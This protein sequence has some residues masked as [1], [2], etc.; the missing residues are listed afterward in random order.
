MNVEELLDQIDDLLDKG[1][2]WPGGKRLV[3]V[4]TI[5]NLIDDIR[6]NM[7]SEV[8]QAKGIVADRAE[9]LNNAKRQEENIIRSAE[10]KAKALVADQEI[11][12][13]AQ[14]RANEI[15]SSAQTK[16]R[17]MRRAAQEFVEDLMKNCDDELA[18]T[19]NELR[20]TRATLRQP[21]PQATQNSQQ[22]QDK[23]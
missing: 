10:E 13:L 23:Q 18:K 14:Q 8:K 15:L 4:E 19:L 21:I 17:D 20:R 16:S 7:P 2:N 6:L 12:R 9:I 5:R 1:M 3:D 11:T 22:N